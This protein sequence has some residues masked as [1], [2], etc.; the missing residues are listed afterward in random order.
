MDIA[1]MSDELHLFCTVFFVQQRTMHF[2]VSSG[3]SN[4]K[5][6]SIRWHYI[7]S[8]SSTRNQGLDRVDDR[9]GEGRR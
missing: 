2:V 8:R 1:A 7:P 9:K 4:F 3:F 6:P 5:A